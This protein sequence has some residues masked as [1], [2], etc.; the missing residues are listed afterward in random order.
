M[1]TSQILSF[2]SSSMIGVILK[3]LNWQVR[4]FF[5]KKKKSAQQTRAVCNKNGDENLEI[6]PDRGCRDENYMLFYT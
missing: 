6:V 4:A 3:S 5:L 1:N 2:Y